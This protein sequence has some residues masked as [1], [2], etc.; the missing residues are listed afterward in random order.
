MSL[1]SLLSS[2]N[3]SIRMEII[4]V[5][6]IYIPIYMYKGMLNVEV[7]ASDADITSLMSPINCGVR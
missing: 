7:A 6:S 1:M 5:Y 2:P 4:Y 3:E